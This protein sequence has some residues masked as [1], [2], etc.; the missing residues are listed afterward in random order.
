V[1]FPEGTTTNGSYVHPFKSAL[2]N[3]MEPQINCDENATAFTVQP[4]VMWFRDAGGNALSDDDLAENYASFDNAKQLHGRS[5]V[6]LRGEFEQLFHVMKRG[7]MRIEIEL[8]PPPSLN[9]IKNRHE[10]AEKMFKIVNDR[11]M[12]LKDKRLIK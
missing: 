8:L 3:I 10:M 12:E 9:G 1:I 7:G 5:D 6:R 11:Y 2:F 4:F